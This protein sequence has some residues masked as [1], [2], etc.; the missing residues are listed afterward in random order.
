MGIASL[1]AGFALYALARPATMPLLFAPGSPALVPSHLLPAIGSLPTFIHVV[2]FSFLSA[3]IAGARAGGAPCVAWAATN[4]VFEVA[5]YPP[6]GQW[7]LSRSTLASELP[8]VHQFVARGTFDVTDVCAA[9]L[10]AAVA[11]WCLSTPTKR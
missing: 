6:V 10:G 4:I 2:A 3:A 11:A 9:A 7:L 1:A 8:Y 5:Q